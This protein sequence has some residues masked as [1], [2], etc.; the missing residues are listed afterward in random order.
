MDYDSDYDDYD[1]KVRKH[2]IYDYHYQLPIWEQHLL[3]FLEPS[4]TPE[5]VLQSFSLS[6]FSPTAYY[7][8]A[9]EPLIIFLAYMRF[10]I[11][12]LP[13]ASVD[14]IWEDILRKNLN[15]SRRFSRC[16]Q[17]FDTWSP[18]STISSFGYYG[19]DVIVPLKGIE[20]SNWLNEALSTHS[21]TPNPYIRLELF[22]LI[23]LFDVTCR[24]TLEPLCNTFIHTICE[25]KPHRLYPSGKEDDVLFTVKEFNCIFSHIFNKVCIHHIIS[26]DLNK[27]LNETH[28][29]IDNNIATRFISHTLQIMGVYTAMA[30]SNSD[31][32]AKISELNH[33]SNILMG[34]MREFQT[35]IV[36]PPFLQYVVETV[37]DF[38]RAIS[39]EDVLM[40]TRD[41]FVEDLA[42]C[43]GTCMLPQML[44]SRQVHGPTRVHQHSLLLSKLCGENRN[45]VE[46]YSDYE[47]A[48]SPS[49]DDWSNDSDY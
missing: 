28:E 48:K 49:S 19:Y 6:C 30:R 37:R 13:E 46:E 36:H 38:T 42:I 10:I 20:I 5:K 35:I 25:V 41:K 29:V 7:P 40:Y 8:S 9:T 1:P 22:R 2:S 32:K 4:T 34:W 27:Q 12:R 31:S 39:N 17:G 11:T 43:H 15:F 23:N 18:N 45:N 16:N 24:I 3:T 44:L 26:I 47:E 21:K 14:G 33:C